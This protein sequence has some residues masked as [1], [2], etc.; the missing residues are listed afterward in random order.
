MIRYLT[1]FLFCLFVAVNC[2]PQNTKGSF[3]VTG[4]VKV[5]QG[6]VDGTRI[7]LFKNSVRIQELVINRT[8][9]FR[10]MVELNQNY[11]FLFS[12]DNYYSKTIDFDTNIPPGVCET[13]CEFP[14][15]EL[16]LQLYKKVPGVSEMAQPKARIS[17]NKQL[18]VFDPEI[19]RQES[20]LKKL[21]NEALSEAKQKAVLYDQKKSMEKKLNYDRLIKE[22]DSYFRTGN[23]DQAMKTYRD[24]AMIFPNE[25]YPRDRVDQAFHL[26]VTS[27]MQKSFGNPSSENVLKYLNY[28]DLKFSE[29]EYTVAKLAYESALAVK[30]DDQTIKAKVEK[31]ENEVRKIK[32]LAWEEINHKRDVYASRTVKYNQLIASGDELLGKENIIDAKDR[33]AQAATQID[34]N[35]YALLMLQKIGEIISNE[36]FAIRLNRERDEADKKRLIEARNKAYYDAIAEADQL[37]TQ[38]LY[39][40]AIENYELA[41]TIKEYELYPRKQIETIKDILAKLQLNGEEYNRLI[42]E[43]DLAMQQTNY[44]PAKESFEKA[45]RLV[46]EEKYALQKIA[47]IDKLMKVQTA[48][49]ALQE[50]YLKVLGEA[51]ALFNQKKYSEAIAS[52]QKASGIKPTEKYPKEQ[53]LKI[54][55]MLSRESDEQKLLLQKQTEYDQVIDQADESFE[56]QSYPSARSLYL[57]ALQIFPGQEYPSNQIK[58]IDELLRQMAENVQ[59]TKSRLDEIDF[60]NL[61]HLN[62][63]DRDAAFKE[64]MELGESF[65]KSKEWGIA[66]FYFR[67]A[68][69]LIPEEATAKQRL[70]DADRMLR[71]NDVDESKFTEFV[72]KA[73]ESFKTGDISVAKFYYAK[74]LEIKP[75][76]T[77]TKERFNVTDQLLRSTQASAGEREFDDAISKGDNAFAAKNYSLARFFYRKALSLKPGNARASEK[78]NQSESALGQEKTDTGNSEYDRNIMLGN[79]A[80]QQQ[81]YGVAKSYYRQ[82]LTIKPNDPYSKEQ[83]SK[84]DQLIKK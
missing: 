78:L 3:S 13:N 28:G 9:T 44:L 69:S 75:A 54:R 30:P 5:D 6:V 15:Y 4:K 73:D 82:A 31:S 41:L 77:Y 35:S 56:R 62:K 20:D 2:F 81:N 52:Y 37:L 45:H 29:R 63:D 40:D 18:D 71:G 84:I 48:E 58:K 68:L 80:F 34:E 27:E 49:N 72:K 12:N 22:A 10:V 14:P 65:M 33:Y 11:R 70:N 21:I 32:D 57:K 60:A 25:K 36:E 24:A 23:L 17:Y 51:D 46:P 64:A 38:R 47:E 42:R 8:G 53:V 7:E 50:Q 55:G 1:S 61:Q 83:L 26:L 67:R 39:L 66:R 59:G 79:Q 19:L 74:A 16:A 76:D 43:G